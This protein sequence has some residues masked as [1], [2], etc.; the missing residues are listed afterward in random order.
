MALYIL[1]CVF[2][3]NHVIVFYLIC[4]QNERRFVL[5]EVAGVCFVYDIT[6]DCIGFSFSLGVKDKT[7]LCCT[8]LSVPLCLCVSFQT[9][10]DVSGVRLH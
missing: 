8:F 9:D 6:V 1:H 3:L 10:L 5:L 7:E 2:K 4:I